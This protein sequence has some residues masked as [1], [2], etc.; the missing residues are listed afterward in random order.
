MHRFSICQHQ[1]QKSECKEM[2]GIKHLG[3]GSCARNTSVPKEAAYGIEGFAHL[4]A[5]GEA[6]ECISMADESLPTGL[7]ALMR[8]SLR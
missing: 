5:S 7:V 8:L 1:H 2:R 3:E 6:D 4:Q